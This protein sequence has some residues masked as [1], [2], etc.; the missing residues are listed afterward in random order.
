MI[1]VAGP[2]GAGKSS[3]FPVAA[4][5]VDFF[6]ADIRASSL[7][8]TSL[9]ISQE[10]RARVNIE[11]QKWILDHISARRS[12]AFE[13]TLRSPI[14][15]EQAA[16]ARGHG[17]QTRLY[18]VSAGGV[19]ENIL[20]IKE[21]AWSGGHSAPQSLIRDIYKKST[22][23]L[24]RALHFR[25]SGIQVV[26]VYDNSARFVLDSL[27]EIMTVREGQVTQLANPVRPWLEAI[28]R[29]TKYDLSRIKQELAERSQTQ[30]SGPER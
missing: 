20:R 24:V 28:L 25:E 21:R 19:E 7:H 2:P 16:L 9:G 18:Y 29:G 14:T 11:F 6:N 22:N 15:F 23:N 13:T 4:F 26:R 27:P 10:I 3:R 12:I 30:D 17:F 5:G 1:V 8:G